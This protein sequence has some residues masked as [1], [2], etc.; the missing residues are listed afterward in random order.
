MDK[1]LT[2][3]VNTVIAG[4]VLVQDFCIFTKLRVGTFGEAF[5]QY[6]FRYIHVL[7]GIMWIGLLYYFNFVQIPNMPNI[8]DEQKTSHWQGDCTCRIMVVPLGRH[9]HNG[10]WFD[11]GSSQWLFT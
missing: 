8:P 10:I 5:A 11:T 6:A 9:V 2:S 7:S 4:F 3:L 1:I